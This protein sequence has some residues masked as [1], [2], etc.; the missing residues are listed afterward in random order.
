MCH[1]V[2]EFGMSSLIQSTPQRT[3]SFDL[4]AYGTGGAEGEI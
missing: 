4:V 2:C 1:N 3:F